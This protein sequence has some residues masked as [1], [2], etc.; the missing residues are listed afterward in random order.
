MTFKNNKIY[1]VLKW[2]ALVAFDSVGVAYK[3]LAGVWGLPYG[4]EIQMT[5]TI[6]SV[7]IG[8]LIGISGAS[9]KGGK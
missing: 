2:L 3:A 7:L 9:Y 1:D 6:V 4:D 5:C 8:A